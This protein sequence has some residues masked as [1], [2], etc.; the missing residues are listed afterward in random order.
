MEK[1]YRLLTFW[2][3]RHKENQQ[4][5]T[6][7]SWDNALF[8]VDYESGYV[9]RVCDLPRSGHLIENRYC[10]L[11]D[12]ENKIVVLPQNCNTLG[13]YDKTQK[14]I[15]EVL[16]PSIADINRYSAVET[17]SHGRN[18]VVFSSKAK[19]MPFVIDLEKLTIN[20][21]EGWRT[22]SDKYS[23][24]TSPCFAGNFEKF[25]N[26]CI[27]GNYGTNEILYFDFCKQKGGIFAYIPQE[28]KICRIYT[29]HDDIWI[30]PLGESSVFCMK[31]GASEKI[32]KITIAEAGTGFSNLLQDDDILVAIPNE[33][34]QIYVLDKISL[35]V[36]S[37]SFQADRIQNIYYDNHPAR[38]IRGGLNKHSIFLFPCQNDTMV[39]IDRLTMDVHYMSFAVSPEQDDYE[40][41]LQCYKGFKTPI[42]REQQIPFSTFLKH[43]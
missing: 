17:I 11:R 19:T 18:C 23:I 15:S 37:I 32:E 28:I 21:L 3:A 35:C 20:E 8:I 43:I 9:E 30:L 41:L 22:L 25:S 10:Y 27:F 38:F 31:D 13:I 6:V 16:L 42:I 40:R 29:Y 33:G 26:G 34:L 5:W 12:F 4:Y 24:S 2:D 7:G 36:H 39:I 1:K 14:S